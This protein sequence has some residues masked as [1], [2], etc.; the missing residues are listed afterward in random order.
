MLFEG[1][2]S[3]TPT[4]NPWPTNHAFTTFCAVDKKS[5]ASEY[6]FSFHIK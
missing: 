4:E 6:P 2:T 5:L 1:T 3:D